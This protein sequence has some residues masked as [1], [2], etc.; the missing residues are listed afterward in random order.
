MTIRIAA[1]LTLVLAT[2]ACA[3]PDPA[4]QRLTYDVALS[5]WAATERAPAVVEAPAVDPA[6]VDPAAV[7]TAATPAEGEAAAV[8]PAA[9]AVP[10]EPVAPATV[11]ADIQLSVL[12]T[13]NG[14]KLDQLTLDIS[15]ADASGTEKATYRRTIDVAQIVRGLE[16]Q[17]TV[18]LENIEIAGRASTDQPYPDQF[19][20]AVRADIP[21]ASRSEYPELAGGN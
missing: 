8:D 2:F 9:E 16:S 6:A 10:V 5:S 3:P 20:V 11:F 19:A 13:N 14:G 7:D 17:V 1:A 21:A 12:V 4:A 15:H 18:V